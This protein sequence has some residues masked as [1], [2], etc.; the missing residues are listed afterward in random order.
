MSDNELLALP[1]SNTKAE[2]EEF[3]KAFVSRTGDSPYTLKHLDRYVETINWIP[4][5]RKPGA[6]VLEFGSTALFQEL[7]RQYFGYDEV[8]G[9]DFE[10]VA[11]QKSHFRKFETIS[12]RP[13]YMTHHVNVESESVP[14]ADGYFD[15]LLACEIVEHMEVD[16]MHFMSEINRIC[17]MG[18]HILITTPNSASS[19]T[20]WA[21]LNGMRPHFYMQYLK[22]RALYRHNYEYDVAMIT[23]LV[24]AAGF[25]IVTLETIDCFAPQVGEAMRLLEREGLPTKHRGDNIFV[26]ARKAAPVRERFPEGIYD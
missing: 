22:T 18:G 24:M 13:W 7:L 10:T 17:A 16:P 4:H 5:A 6:R 9:T 2:W 19:R 20:L 26:L 3:I 8:H 11:D 12:T 1:K 15:F 21:V 23:K 14:V 25:D